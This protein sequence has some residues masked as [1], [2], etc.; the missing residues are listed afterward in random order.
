[1]HISETKNTEDFRRRKAFLIP[2]RNSRRLVMDLSEN[3]NL[4]CKHA[5]LRPKSAIRPMTMM[6]CTAKL[7]G[8]RRALNWNMMSG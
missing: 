2:K 4:F 7:R 6:F 1:M 3:S 5:E 8:R